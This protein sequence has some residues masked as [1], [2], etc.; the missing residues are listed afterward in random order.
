M[1]LKDKH[2]FIVEDD[3]RNRAVL[4]TILQRQGALTH[5]DQWGI[6][7]IDRIKEFQQIDLILL[8]LMLPRGVSGY[9]VYDQLQAE[10]TLAH[11]PVVIVSASDPALEMN[12]ARKRGLQGYISK[13]INHLTFAQSIASLLDGNEI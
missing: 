12:K 4:I 10:P 11:I 13:P 5:F 3:P 7:T 2:I 9:D 1:L 8:D 6:Q